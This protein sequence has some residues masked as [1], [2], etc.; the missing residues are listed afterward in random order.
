MDAEKQ[1]FIDGL[2]TYYK[3][4]N[5]YLEYILQLKK[6]IIKIPDL[7]WKEKRIEYQRVKPKCINCKRPVGSIFSTKIEDLE[8]HLIAL[9]GDKK[10]P[11]TLN[12]NIGLG[13]IYNLQNDI[14]HDEKIISDLKRE[15]VIDKNDL[16]FGYIT[17]KDAVEKFDI[18][19][20]KVAEITKMYEYS[21]Q[22]YLNIANNSEKKQE[23]NDIQVELYRNLITFN[24]LIS[25][26]SLKQEIQ[27][28]IDAITLY[29]DNINPKSVELRNKRYVYS[30]VEYNEW[31]DVYT[32][33]QI[34]ISKE[35]LEW[36]ISQKG[37]RVISLKM[38][39]IIKKSKKV[40]HESAIPDIKK[41]R[42]K[43]DKDSKKPIKKTTKK[44]KLKQITESDSEKS[45]G[46][47]EYLDGG[48]VEDENEY[49]EKEDDDEQNQY[50]D[51]EPRKRLVIHP[52]DF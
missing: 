10:D 32:L 7:N 48:Y 4:K 19:K 46:S 42:K 50:N 14:Y 49:I 36:N 2:N 43:V 20:D 33:I 16:L 52:A 45:G 34:P 35:N 8:R 25:E 23:I 11:C 18:I 5:E 29:N 9:C 51:F 1:E 21:L 44:L 40:E 26:Y 30:N 12:I 3:L 22:E 38:G 13:L 31:D 41:S 28:I 39:G 24:E 37:Q 47:N 27:Y 15:I 17:A 6:D